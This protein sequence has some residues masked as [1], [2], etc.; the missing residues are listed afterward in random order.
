MHTLAKVILTVVAVVLV[1]AAGMFYLDH[2]LSRPD[3][4]AAVRRTDE[5][6]SV[7]DQV[8]RYELE[9]GVLPRTLNELIPRYLRKNQVQ[10]SAGPLYRYD[11]E[12][13]RLAQ[14]R[15]NAVLGLRLSVRPPVQMEL[16][17]L[18]PSV[19]TS[20]PELPSVETSDLL[21]DGMALLPR[22]ADLPQAPTGSYVFEAE[23]FTRMN[24]G[25]EVHPDPSC[26]GG[27]YL[28]S[29][30]GTTN[31]PAQT[32]YGLGNF[33]DIRP[34]TDYTVLRHHFHLPKAGRYYVYGRMWTTDTHC[35]NSVKAAIDAGG[36]ETGYM[37]NRTPFHWVWTPVIGSPMK[38]SAGDHF[39]HIFI[40]E[41]GIRLDQF[42]LSPT[43]IWGRSAYRANL[44]PGAD[45]AWQASDGPPLHVSFDLKSMVIGPD[46]P[47]DCKVVL[48]RL[49][50]TTEKVLLRVT[51]E[52]SALGGKNWR[53]AEH[54]VDL[55]RL[56]EV[57]F[58]PL[59]FSGLDL[60]HVARREY[61][62]RAEV[63]SRDRTIASAR[64][65]LLKPFSWEVAGPYGYV[66]NGRVG[67]LDGDRELPVT[68]KP[69]WVSFR[70][71]NMDHFGVLDFGLHTSGNSLHA[72][73]N[74]SI[75]ARTRLRVPE[76]DDYL[77]LLQTDDGVTLWI[78]GV[79]VC[80]FDDDVDKPVTRSARRLRVHLSAGEHRLRMR[81]NQL[82]DR[83]QAMLR[84][85]TKDD[86]ISNVTGLPPATAELVRE[87][88]ASTPPT[89]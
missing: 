73:E 7:R 43:R 12:K 37:R 84:V 64:V 65:T 24:Y 59:S 85:R 31:G 33:F 76:S 34:T 44:L 57:C 9:H 75:Y 72:I 81:V 56:P 66:R 87:A 77:L 29:W 50:P 58:V 80:Q 68:H 47:P 19:T 62:L 46:F 40:H 27:A 49:R 38:L 53:V 11:P 32:A 63:T 67:P 60:R 10:D 23:H 22:G 28:H 15:A 1:G 41:D 70:E 88:T 17:V 86:D 4:I 35:S 6:I 79:L 39:L 42:I 30:E 2:V 52:G 51:L 21:S 71:K 25:W 55:A 78:D 74:R 48:R 61:L 54:T 45:T 82:F 83:W 36:P 8:L 20:V 13:R 3:R 5:M 14:S 26:S 69:V 18:D 89:P 16:P